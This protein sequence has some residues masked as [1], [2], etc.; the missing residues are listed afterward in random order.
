MK[1]I[2]KRP[3]LIECADTYHDTRR[4]SEDENHDATADSPH[5]RI[6]AY[7]ILQ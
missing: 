5:G 7:G 6:F 2:G 1:R 4:G 3:I